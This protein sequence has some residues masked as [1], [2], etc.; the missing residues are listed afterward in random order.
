MISSNSH[1]VRIIF[2][3]ALLIFFCSLLFQCCDVGRG[4]GSCMAQGDFSAMSISNVS[5]LNSIST[6]NNTLSIYSLG[7]LVGIDATNGLFF[8][9]LNSAT[10]QFSCDLIPSSTNQFSFGSST[11]HWKNIHSNIFHGYDTLIIG[12]YTTNGIYLPGALTW[13][14]TSTASLKDS[15]RNYTIS[16]TKKIYDL[17]PRVF[18][19]KKSASTDSLHIDT[20]KE[21]LGFIADE[22]GLVVGD[23]TK[24]K[25]SLTEIVALQQLAIKDLNERLKSLGK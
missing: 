1:P 25:I 21:Q 23:A 4:C 9:F 7:G 15:I 6:G 18:K 8:N 20:K 2:I 12:D 3:N 17:S 14:V 10:S 24:Q 19:W 16:D 11:R 13:V 22:V 5:Q